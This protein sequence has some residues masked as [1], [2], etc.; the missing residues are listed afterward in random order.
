MSIFQF[1]G[2]MRHSL[3]SLSPPE[4]A[5]ND[6]LAPVVLRDFF[7]ALPSLSFLSVD[8]CMGRHAP[9]F[10][11]YLTIVVLYQRLHRKLIAWMQEQVSIKLM[12]CPGGCTCHVVHTDIGNTI[13][14]LFQ[15]NLTEI[16]V[17]CNM[18]ERGLVQLV[19]SSFNA[20][21]DFYFSVEH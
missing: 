20:I 8:T 5:S 2:L 17:C 18:F 14:I 6:F 21:C 9:L 13:W 3:V 1:F 16:G 11:V 7:R 4:F 19:L 10:F 15:N 12:R